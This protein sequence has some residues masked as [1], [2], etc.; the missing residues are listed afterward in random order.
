MSKKIAASNNAMSS[1]TL[2]QDQNESVKLPAF[3]DTSV[4]TGMHVCSSTAGVQSSSAASDL[5]V[6]ATLLV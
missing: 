3:R 1:N 6:H 5:L 2:S 4:S